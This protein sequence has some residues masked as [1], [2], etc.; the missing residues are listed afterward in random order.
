MLNG[1]MIQ[2]FEWNLADDG[3]HW[4]RLKNDAAH[5]KEI[6][7]SAV[8]IP[9]AYKGTFSGDVGYSAYDLWDLGEFNQKGTVRTKYGTKEELIDAINELHK[10]GINVYL[11]AVLNHKGGADETERFLAIEVDPENRN[12]EISEP[13]EI[14]GWTK[15]TFPGRNKKYSEFEWNHALFSGVDYD[16]LT[17][18][19]AIYK[20]AGENK[21]WAENVDSEL[22]NYDYLMNADVDYS[23]PEVRNEIINW[24][25]WVVNELNLDG[26]RMDAVKHISEDFIK[27]FLIEVRKVYGEKFYSVGEYWKGDLDTLKTY[28][29]NIGYETDLFD[30]GLHFNFHEASVEKENYDLTTI[31]DNSI[32]LMD[33]IKAVT[34]VD[35]HDSQKGS[36]LESEI[37][38]WF[39]PHAYAIIL[40]SEKGYPC[41]FYGDYYGV[42]DNKS[43]HGWVIDKLLYVRRNNAYGEQ[44]NYFDDPNIIAF[45]RKGRENEINTGCV[46]ILSNNEDG[47]KAIEIGKD[48]IGQVWEEVTGSGFEDV[49]IDE[50]GNAAFRVEGQKI[51][52]W[53][54]KKQ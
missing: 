54:P 13:K 8:W 46:A 30:V 27:E 28:L 52:V 47:E 39:I 23:H 7:V 31:L 20:I 3:K 32:M 29:E 10:Y 36:A 11:D 18:K 5:L 16:N 15:F 12:E 42:G 25:K 19:T 24:G 51:A 45:Y 50:E 40:L 37:E 17:G 43:P 41:L 14:E 49:A 6:G 34:F 33:P 48:R 44:I 35:N 2:Y 4:E 38:S 9:P 26:F 1:V 53:V 21:G 22:G